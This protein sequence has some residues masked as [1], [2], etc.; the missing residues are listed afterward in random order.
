MRPPSGE[1]ETSAPVLKLAK[2]NKRKRA[3]TSEDPEL[4]TRTARKPRKNTIPLTEESVQRLRDEDEEEEYD[5]SGLVSRVKMS[6]E[7]PNATESMKA[8]GVL[9]CDEGVSGRELVEVPESSRIEA[10]SHHNETVVGT[11]AGA[12]LEAPR[13]G[14][15]SLSDSLGAIEIGGS[16]LFP[17][18]SEEMI[19]EARAL[20]TLFIKGGH[21]RED[22]FREY[23][24]GVEDITGLGDLEVSRKDSGEA[25]SLFNEVQ[26]ALNRDSMLH[27]EAC[28]RSRA[29]M[30]SARPTSEGSHR[31]EM[32]SDFSVGKKEE[33]TKDLRAELAKAHQDQTDLIEQVMKL[34]KAHGLDSGTMAN[35]SISQ[36]QQKI[37]R[38]EQFREEVDMIR[39]ESLGWKEGM[40]RLAAEKET[41]RAQLSSVKNQL[42]GMKEKSSI[43][44]K[45]IE[46]LEAQLSSKLA[47]AKSESEKAKT[48]AEEIVVVYRA[49]AKAAQ[50]QFGFPTLSLSEIHARGFD[51]TEEIIKAKELEAESEALASDDDD[52]D[53]S[54]SGSESGEDFDGEETTPGDN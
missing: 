29:E 27:R 13:D 18:F 31:R 12:G 43:Q 23:F 25:S 47:K 30:S 39:V 16:P 2:D 8:T 9:F 52:D 6:A 36:L 34:L 46:E 19:R 14:E 35:V 48:E 40:D 37:E 53:E 21:G 51:L 7:A 44:E 4:K 10:T 50:V 41:T 26:R 28:S 45:K 5:D 20:K 33:G 11:V 1:E 3:S 42:Q 17:S 54:K 49:D 15:N 24:T 38:I 22:P 32:P